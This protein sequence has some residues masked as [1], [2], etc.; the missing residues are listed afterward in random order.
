MKGY[1]VSIPKNRVVGV[2]QHVRNTESLI[3]IKASEL[4]EA[5]YG[6]ESH[7]E[8]YGNHVKRS[9]KRQSSGW[10]RDRHLV[11]TRLS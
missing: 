10:T 1:R 6:T 9:I 7:E 8:L 4:V 5:F 11:K 3:D 2:I